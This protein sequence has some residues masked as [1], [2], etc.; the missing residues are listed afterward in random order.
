[1]SFAVFRSQYPEA[2]VQSPKSLCYVISRSMRV[3][4]LGFCLRVIVN[5]TKDDIYFSICIGI[6]LCLQ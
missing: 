1:M 6:N 2:E 5:E 4:P 3:T